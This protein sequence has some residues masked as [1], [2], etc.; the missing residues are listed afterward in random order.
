[1]KKYLLLIAAV[2]SFTTAFSQ[3]HFYL[4]F[5]YNLG[6]AKLDA[7]HTYGVDRY[8]ETRTWLTEPMGSFH[9]PNG[10]CASLGGSKNKLMYDITWVGR[11]MTRS[12]SGTQPNG[13]EGG[14]E[15]KWRMNTIN[16]GFGVALGQSRMARLNIGI[17]IDMGNEKVFTRTGENGVFNPEEFREVQKDIVVGS[18]IFMQIILSTENLPAGLFIRPYIQL[19][20]FKTNYLDTHDELDKTNTIDYEAAKSTS[21]NVG[22]QMQI[23]LFKRSD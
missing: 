14:R 13:I 12:A 6:Y 8:N 7:L 23:G 11:H 4:N 20:Y 2:F 9:F 16:F 18:T 17:S 3:S 10:F 22:V 1:M 5:G 19:P 15:L 21:W